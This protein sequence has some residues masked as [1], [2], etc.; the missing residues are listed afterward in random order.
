MASKT[1]EEHENNFH[2]TILDII[3]IFG[4][5]GGIFVLVYVFSGGAF[6]GH[7]QDYNCTNVTDYVEITG[8]YFYNCTGE[9]E[10]SG[11]TEKNP[12][13]MPFRTKQVCTQ[14]IW[15]RDKK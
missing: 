15:I 6:S 10:K 1:I 2:A 12:C 14:E 13:L 5:A 11:C 8:Y 7:W 4:S 3:F 9:C